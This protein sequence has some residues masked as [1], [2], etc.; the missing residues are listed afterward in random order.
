MDDSEALRAVITAYRRAEGRWIEGARSEE[1]DGLLLQALGLP[2]GWANSAVVLGPLPD[3]GRALLDARSWFA[4]RGLPMSVNVEDGRPQV[5]AAARAMGLRAGPPR[6]GMTR[7]TRPIPEVPS[8]GVPIERARPKQREEIAAAQAAGFD[9]A[10]DFARALYPE[11]KIEQTTVLLAVDEGA[12]VGSAGLFVHDGVGII[13]G[14]C[15]SPSHRGRGLGR[16]LMVE[17]MRAAAGAGCDRVT[18]FAAEGK[19]GFYRALGFRPVY[20]ERTWSPP[21][22]DPE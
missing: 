4:R 9:M 17:S 12:P 1:R 3:A 21:G 8:S 11:Q 20:T 10:L 16:E 15:T 18:L 13:G 19:D 7:D 22:T 14:V 6:L 5:E 2:A